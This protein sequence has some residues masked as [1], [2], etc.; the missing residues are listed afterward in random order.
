MGILNQNAHLFPIA[1]LGT[2]AGENEDTGIFCNTWIAA[3]ITTRNR[4]QT[5]KND[6]LL[7]TLSI[8]K[9]TRKRRW[10]PQH[11]VTARYT[12]RGF[13]TLPT[14]R[15]YWQATNTRTGIIPHLHR[16]RFS[17]FRLRIG[18]PLGLIPHF[19]KP[20][21]S[22][23]ASSVASPRLLHASLRALVRS[24]NRAFNAHLACIESRGAR[25]T[26]NSTR[27]TICDG[28]ILLLPSC[29]AP[30]VLYQCSSWSAWNTAIY[31][32]CTVFIGSSLALAGTF[33]PNS[34]CSFSD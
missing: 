10:Q 22:F 25:T 17:G 8:P 18:L 34:I 4:A 20:W 1:K 28:L 19:Q 21:R 32:V 9:E 26:R 3:P 30:N 12:R 23:P 29:T 7:A 16:V 33:S 2:S 14:G 6:C 27:S 31:K 11:R 5:A 13:A 24:L 15:D